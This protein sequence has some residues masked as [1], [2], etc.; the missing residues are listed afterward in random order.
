[1]GAFS[2]LHISMHDKN[3]KRPEWAVILDDENRPAVLWKILGETRGFYFLEHGRLPHVQIF[4]RAD[5][6]WIV[7]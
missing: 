4:E 2:D 3:E 5:N 7:A 6:V 1:M